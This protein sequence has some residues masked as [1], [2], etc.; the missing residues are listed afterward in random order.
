L[1]WD[2]VRPCTKTVAVND[3]ENKY[4]CWKLK[5]GIPREGES[6]TEMP[7]LRA[8]QHTKGIENA[9]ENW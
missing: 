1:D 7:R 2:E 8:L 6:G 5:D 3:G 9:R 4:I